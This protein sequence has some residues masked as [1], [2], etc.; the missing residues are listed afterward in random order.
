MLGEGNDVASVVELSYGQ[1]E[2]SKGSFAGSN[3][4]VEVVGPGFKFVEWEE[5]H[6]SSGIKVPTED[7]LDLDGCP[8]SN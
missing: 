8:L 1:S 4:G 2:F 7:N 5:D 6:E 3:N